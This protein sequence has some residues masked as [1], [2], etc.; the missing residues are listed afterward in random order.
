MNSINQFDKI[1]RNVIKSNDGCIILL[2]ESITYDC[3]KI[4]VTGLIDMYLWDHYPEI[5]D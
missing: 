3:F 1:F 4:F 5:F 2:D